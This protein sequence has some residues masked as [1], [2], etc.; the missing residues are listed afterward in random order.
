MI[1]SLAGALGIHSKILLT[2]NC[3]YFNGVN[4]SESYWFP[5][6]K[7]YRQSYSEGWNNAFTQIKDGIKNS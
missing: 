3:L 5:S 1:F 7:F 4:E 6:Q 2:Y